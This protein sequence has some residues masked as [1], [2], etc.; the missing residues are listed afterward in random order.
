MLICEKGFE[1][2]FDESACER[3]GGKCCTGQS[4]NVFASNDEI[5]LLAAHLGLKFDEFAQIYLRKVRWKWSFKE[6]EFENG[7]ACVFFDT[8]RRCCGIYELRPRQ[9][10]SFP[11]WE[12]FKTHK[13]ELK[14]EC[15]G[16]CF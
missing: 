16:V 3:C 2:S 12:Y 8:Q 10:R 11:F 6:V 13:E 7:F 15:I 9:C 4:G 5:A 1:F 14:Q